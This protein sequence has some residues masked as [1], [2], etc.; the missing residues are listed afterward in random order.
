LCGGCHDLDLAHRYREVFR[1][2]AVSGLESAK[3]KK[4]FE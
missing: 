2:R 1:A 4:M 3:N